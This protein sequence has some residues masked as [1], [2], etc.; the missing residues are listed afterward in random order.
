MA[1]NILPGDRLL[2]NKIKTGVRFPNSVLGLPGPERAYIDAFRI[3]YFRFPGVRK[4]KREDVVAFNDPR[5]SDKPIDRS[6]ILISRIAGLPGDTV[7]LLDKQLYIN[8]EEVA[9]SPKFRRLYRVVTDGSP[10]PED[11]ISEYQLEEPRMV[12]E[13]GIYDMCLDSAAFEAIKELPVIKNI[14]DRQQFIG[15]S[16]SGYFPYSNFYMWNRDQVGPLIVPYKG[17]KVEIS[18]KTVDLYREI[19]SIYEG[20][21]LVV[22][23]SG[24]KI[25]GRAV[26]DYTFKKDYFYI[27][28]D[29]RDNPNDSRI[30]GF[31]PKSHLLGTSKRIIYSGKSGFDNLRDKGLRILKKISK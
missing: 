30:I 9:S 29:N 7:I 27:L 22:D 19:I 31:I 23:F 17:F 11:F 1:S 16:S 18:I 3:P 6:P 4:F 2:V 12:A 8:R 28:D 14:R 25:N 20:N 21:D 26:Q 13:I 24:V 15:D 10:I 5:F